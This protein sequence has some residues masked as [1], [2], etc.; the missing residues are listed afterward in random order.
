MQLITKVF[1]R[2]IEA[3]KQHLCPICRK[4]IDVRDFKDNLSKKEYNISGLCQT[5]QDE[6]LTE[7]RTCLVQKN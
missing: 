7:Y 6:I 5:C 4:E 3:V 1:P 2:E